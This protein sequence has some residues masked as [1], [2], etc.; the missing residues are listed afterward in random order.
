M[1]A[2]K[3]K[4]REQGN[5]I[6]ERTKRF[7]IILY[8]YSQNYYEEKGKFHFIASGIIEGEEK[9]KK[10]FLKDLK[11]DKKVTFLESHKDFLI[12]IYSEPKKGSRA[13]V[14]VAYNPRLIFIKPAII[15]KEGWEEWEIASVRRKDLE[16][17][18]R[19]SKSIP[20]LEFKLLYLKQEKISNLMI[21]SI[22]PKLTDKQKKCLSLAIGHGYY[23]YPRKIKLKE[24][25]KQM[26]ISLSTFQFH[27][28]RA[29]AKV[30]P[31][32]SKQQ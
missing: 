10:E 17:L 32:L 25:A 29:E 19:A 16:D 24:L 7:K 1:W 4:A 21:Y 23:G 28:A 6:E 11:K 13:A 12:C 30:I 3:F 20:N 8:F 26:K 5:L 18:I 27:L 14:K 9:N 2:L 31:F 22:L 15:D